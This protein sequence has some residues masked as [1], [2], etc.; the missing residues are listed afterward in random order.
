MRPGWQS[1][2][3]SVSLNGMPFRLRRDRFTQYGIRNW[4]WLAAFLA[5][6]YVPLLWPRGAQAHALL[7]RADPPPNAQLT[8]PPSAI[9]FWFS[10]PLEET[11]T[12]AR[13][14]RADGTEILT[15]AAA[16]DPNDPTHL[17]LALENFQPGIYTVVWQT[18]SSVDGHE[19]VGS[20]PLTILNADGTRPSGSAVTVVEERQ[21]SLPP[22]VDSLLR[23]LS[24]LGAALLVGPLS[25]RWLLA[26]SGTEKCPVHNLDGLISSTALAGVL[27]LIVGGWLEFLFQSLRLGGIGEFLELLLATRPGRLLLMRQT[28][29]A[30]VVPLLYPNGWATILFPKAV[31]PD[32]SRRFAPLL[33]TYYVAL[34]GLG[35]GGTLYYG[36]YLWIFV[37]AI[38]FI[39]SGWSELLFGG[40]QTWQKPFPQRSWATL[41]TGAALYTFSASG[42]AAAARGSGWAV[43]ADFVHLAAAAAWA[44]GLLLLALL[45]LRL[46][47]MET[48]TDADGLIHL[49]NRFSLSA[50]GAVFLLALTGLFSSFVQLPTL[51]SLFGT[52][53]GQVLLVKLGIIAVIMALAFLNNRAVQHAAETVSQARIRPFVRR[54]ALE[55]VM[56]VALL[57]SVAVLVQTPTPN[58][59]AP[60]TPATPS[61]PF[62]EMTYERD[63][64]IHMQVTPNRVGHN[65]Y[66]VHLSHADSS[67]IGDV[68]LVRL[69]FEHESGQMGQARLDLTELG[70]DAFGAEGAF[71]NRDGE[72]NVS[73][74][75]RRRGLD[76]VL[77][78]ISVS[79][80][81]PEAVQRLNRSPWLNPI[82]RLP[83]GVLVGGL[84]IALSLVPLLWRRAL[85]RASRPLYMV[86]VMGALFFF[87]SGALLGLVAFSQLSE[88]AA[89]P[90]S[91]RPPIH[92][93]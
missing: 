57:V 35:L 26:R 43:A 58:L 45:L 18:L 92:T 21:K 82:P 87:L 16:I 78:E 40:E 2:R 20:F 25:M 39:S 9:E 77:A 79:V 55:A 59:P 91:Q 62:N 47:R 80:P 90:A 17:T 29:L 85:L 28:L 72:W 8:Q 23:W 37:A 65:S 42:H 36:P 73:I 66:R 33:F 27:L 5:L 81:S 1:A 32:R 74:Y 46:R 31:R 7:V 50:Q 11:F 56:A 10:E 52:S 24:L 4:L 76:D 22:L 83:A 93:S 86:L 53:Y 30:G 70:E 84:L 68:Q 60:T 15:G 48:V 13:I 34:L 12:G 54:V 75:V 38:M 89:P 6:L 61:L 88:P 41:L 71:L 69:L 64:A 14:L 67:D 63:L 19:W 44:G 49:L 3:R 51:G